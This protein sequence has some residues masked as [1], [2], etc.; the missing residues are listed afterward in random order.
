MILELENLAVE[1]IIGDLPDERTHLQTLRVDVALTLADH[2]AWSDSLDDTVDYAELTETIRCTL[3]KAECRM[4]ER[5]AFLVAE[6]CM[7]SPLVAEVTAKVT[8]T[9]AVAHLGAA[10]AVYHAVRGET[11][12]K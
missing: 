2:A 1:C 4:I 3:I 7:A 9:G 6:V 5:A 12:E 11:D 8:K 10:R